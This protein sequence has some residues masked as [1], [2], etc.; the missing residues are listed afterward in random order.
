VNLLRPLLSSTDLTVTDLLVPLVDLAGGPHP[1]G[2]LRLEGDEGHP[3]PLR[4]LGGGDVVDDLRGGGDLELEL[5]VAQGDCSTGSAASLILCLTLRLRACLGQPLADPGAE[6]ELEVQPCRDRGCGPMRAGG[7]VS[8][9][10]ADHLHDQA[11]VQ[12]VG[13]VDVFGE[14]VGVYQHRVRRHIDAHVV[15]G[16][17]QGEKLHIGAQ[18]LGPGR[19]DRDRA[20]DRRLRLGAGSCVGARDSQVD[21]GGRGQPL[22]RGHEGLGL[23]R[24]IGALGLAKQG[25]DARQHLVVGHAPHA[26][27]HLRRVHRDTKPSNAETSCGDSGWFLA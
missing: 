12:R 4:G 5:L 15:G 2:L 26:K 24:I 17:D 11:G 19:A 7:E 3:R 1:L 25:G 14:A 16:G 23:V 18:P 8:L 10:G 21:R 22:R 6:R 13:R 27:R 20:L 9:R